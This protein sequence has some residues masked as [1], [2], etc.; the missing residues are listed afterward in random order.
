MSNPEAEHVH[1][2]C[3]NDPP[4]EGNQQSSGE[5]I[6]ISDIE[7]YVSKPADPDSSKLLLFFT[8]G[9]GFKSVNNQL[10]ADQYAKEG[11][12]VLMPD[13]FEG[14]PAPNAASVVAQAESNDWLETVKMAAVGGVKQFMIDM[15]LARHSLERTLPV[16]ERFYG[17]AKQEFSE[18]ASNGIYAVGYCF[19][20]KYVLRL[21][22]AG[23]LKAG[24]VAHGILTLEDFKGLKS[25][26]SLACV[27][28]DPFF[29]DDARK[30]AEDLLAD[31]EL[32][33]EFRVYEGVPHGTV[34]LPARLPD[35]NRPL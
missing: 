7:T 19:G 29:A 11:Y 31:S 2:H 10:Q 25:P 32:T 18:Q 26:I 34:T 23:K 14:D 5:I 3:T 20:A 17:A 1:D 35:A 30:Q 24:A 12:F 6:K 28:G 33:H 22:S 8:N 9:V 15:W 4:L 13:L 27:V 21:N 16:V